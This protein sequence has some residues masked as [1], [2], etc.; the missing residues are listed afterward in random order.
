[1]RRPSHGLPAALRAAA[2]IAFVLLASCRVSPTGTLIGPSVGRQPW[3]LVR[4]AHFLVR[5]D[6]GGVETREIAVDLERT[7]RMLFDLGFPLEKDPG[8][9]TDVIVF[10]RKDD[11]KDV[12]P[13]GSGGYYTGSLGRWAY[14]RPTFLTYGGLSDSARSTFVHE[15]THRFIHYAF[16]QM[17]TWANEGLADYFQTIAVEGGKA[18]IGRTEYVFKRGDSWTMGSYGVPIDALPPIDALMEMGPKEFYAARVVPKGEGDKPDEEAEKEALR[19]QT[20]N[21]ASA[22]SVVHTLRNGSPENAARFQRWL[23]KMAAGEPA[24]PAFDAAFA[25]VSLDRIEAERRAML[26]RLVKR[27]ISLLRTDYEVEGAP[28]GEDRPMRPA[29]ID[30]MWGWVLGRKGPNALPDVQRHAEAA[31]K[32]DPSSGEAHALMAAV[33]LAQE[34]PALADKEVLAAAD[35]APGDEAAAYTLFTFQASPPPG[36]ER[37]PDRKAL[38]EAT[39]A[40]W[41]PRARL[42]S[43]LNSFAWYMALSGRAEEAVAVARRATMLDPSCEAC[44][45][46]LAVA[47]FRSGQ[48]KAAA[49]VEELAAGLAGEGGWKGEFFQRTELYRAAHSAIVIW[50]KRPE[51]GRDPSLL[52]PSV[53]EAIQAAERMHVLEC[54]EEGLRRD[55]KLAGAVVVRGEIGKDGKVTGAA[56]VPAAEW[57]GLPEKSPMPPLRDAAVTACIVE[58]FAAARFPESS[59]PTAFVTP[60]ALKR[61]ATKEP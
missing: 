47:L 61:P 38:A 6:V 24:R 12:G 54:Y 32:E 14:G 33:Y 36:I 29:E 8:I 57:D 7:Y 48:Y 28:P 22:W 59:A 30:V 27:D 43:T 9:F 52:P 3:H 5:S 2:M 11:Y 37:T 60:I 50:K 51:P 25:G 10:R 44:F 4:S 18:V 31:L 17:P 49:E 23:E 53:V 19:K 42:P 20:A 45:D 46:T 39:L 13:A 21:Y 56:A 1:M 40:R 26:E 16:P 35:A 34:K 55:P 15:L 41:L 58:Q